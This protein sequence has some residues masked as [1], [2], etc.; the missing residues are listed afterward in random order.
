MT[1]LLLL[2]L[3]LFATLPALRAESD[4]LQIELVSEQSSVQPGHSFYVGLHLRHRQGYHTY[5]SYP[6]IVGVPTAMAWK[7]PPGFTAG[8]IEWPA[9]ER[10]LMYKIK[11]QGFEGE[12]ILPIKITP[13][14]NLPAEQ[15]NLTLQGKASWMCCGEDCNPGFKEL[16]LT[17]PFTPEAPTMNASTAPL[18]AQAHQ[19]V[20]VPLH[21]WSATATLAG[22]KVVIHLTP[23]SAV[24]RQSLPTLKAG[25]FFTEDGVTDANKLEEFEKDASGVTYSLGLSQYAPTP[26]PKTL[27]GVVAASQSWTPQGGKAMSVELPLQ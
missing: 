19:N 24:A 1:R 27:R 18:F 13:P 22:D 11:A 15:K 16:T 2:A 10:V 20:S 14:D 12:C 5:W 26:L 4:P 9:P 25:T 8:P 21:D 3:T 17:L 6:G 7:L 23:T